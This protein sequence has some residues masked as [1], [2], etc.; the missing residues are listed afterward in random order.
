[1]KENILR[2]IPCEA[3]GGYLFCP[4]AGPL[5]KVP[6][7]SE[8]KAAFEEIQILLVVNERGRV[9]KVPGNI[10]EK[11]LFINEA[12]FNKFWKAI[13]DTIP[14]AQADL[15]LLNRQGQS[16]CIGEDFKIQYEETD[17]DIET[18]RM[19]SKKAVALD[20]HRIGFVYAKSGRYVHDKSCPLIDKIRYWDFEASE[21][22]P[23]GRELCPKCV[24]EIY[25]RNAIKND[26]K[27]FSHYSLFFEKGTVSNHVLEEFLY[28]TGAEIQMD[29]PDELFVKYKK[30]TWK[31][32][33]DENQLCRLYHNNYVMLSERERYITSGFHLQKDSPLYLGGV[34]LYLKE[35]DWQKHLAAKKEE[36]NEPT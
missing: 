5:K 29:T 19:L 17:I 27:H 8:N 25:I 33:M 35:Y 15:T 10:G 20:D 16:A 14:L 4:Y 26:R 30:D 22:L 23:E 12:N 24:R 28:G 6:E 9:V 1:M 36:K 32:K 34:L 3:L 31:I 7:Y 18:E 11:K 13:T 2:G 21:N